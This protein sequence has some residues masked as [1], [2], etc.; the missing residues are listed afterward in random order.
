MAKERFEQA[1]TSLDMSDEYRLARLLEAQFY[2]AEGERRAT[3]RVSLR[4]LILEIVVI[5][6]IG[7]EICLAVK[8]GKDDDQSMSKQNAILT[9]LQT[10]SAATSKALSNLLSAT[11]Q[12]RTSTAATADTL[13]LLE[14]TTKVMSKGVYDQLA[15]FY[16]PQLTITYD[17]TNNRLLVTNTG[18]SNLH[19]TDMSLNGGHLRLDGAQR[20]ISPATAMF[21]ELSFSPQILAQAVQHK[22]IEYPLVVQI[23]NDRNIPFVVNARVLFLRNKDKVETIVQMLNIVRKH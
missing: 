14:S 9:N 3:S 7:G 1:T 17:S 20:L 22:P 21:A 11:N 18:K 5:I 23:T 15:L 4:D 6:L 16:E 2:L 13:T 12:M 8:Q 19:L 10:S